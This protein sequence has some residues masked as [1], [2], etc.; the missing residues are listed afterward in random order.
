[1]NLVVNVTLYTVEHFQLVANIL[2]SLTHEQRLIFGM[3]HDELRY[4]YQI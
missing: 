1:M 3:P 4:Y 2:V